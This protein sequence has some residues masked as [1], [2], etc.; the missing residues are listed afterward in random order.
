MQSRYTAGNKGWKDGFVRNEARG[1]GRS[2]VL[3]GLVATRKNLE[4]IMKGQWET[5][6]RFQ[7]SE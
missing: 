4:C 3:E 2:Q 6:E 1:R 5:A 7:A